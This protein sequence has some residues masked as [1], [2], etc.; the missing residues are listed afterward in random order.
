MSDQHTRYTYAEK[1]LVADY[2]ASFSGVATCAICGRAID[3]TAPRNHPRSF[4]A[5]HVVP[6][7]RGGAHVVENLRPVHHGCNASRGNRTNTTPASVTK[8]VATEPIRRSMCFCLAG[9]TDPS[10]VCIAITHECGYA[11]LHYSNLH[12]STNTTHVNTDTDADTDL[13]PDD[14]WYD[15]E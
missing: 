10:H 7:S 4:N 2:K 6:L 11:C 12:K 1:K 5:D 3:F 9:R 8:P 15:D 14:D 13:D